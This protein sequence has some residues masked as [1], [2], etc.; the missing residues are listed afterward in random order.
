MFF[1]L[2]IS[3]SVRKKRKCSGLGDGRCKG[4]NGLA[5]YSQEKENVKDICFLRQ[6]VTRQGRRKR[7]KMS[8]RARYIGRDF[9]P[10][11]L[12]RA[13][14]QQISRLRSGCR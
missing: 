14:Q 3:F 4:Y 11:S 8:K 12:D 2:L 1:L 6:Y 9:D 5:G 7:I 13:L 10:A